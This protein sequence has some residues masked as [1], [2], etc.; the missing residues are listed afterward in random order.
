MVYLKLT[1]DLSCN[2]AQTLN[3]LEIGGPMLVLHRI[4]KD[5]N[6]FKEL[7][8]A[9]SP[10]S[11]QYFIRQDKTISRKWTCLSRAI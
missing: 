3:I 4:S 6:T 9:F 8:E 1:Y 10:Y 2:L 11:H 7:E 5:K